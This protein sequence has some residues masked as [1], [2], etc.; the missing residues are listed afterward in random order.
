MNKNLKLNQNM[1]NDIKKNVNGSEKRYKKKF[2]LDKPKE[3]VEALMNAYLEEH[4]FVKSDKYK[5]Q[6]YRS[7]KAHMFGFNY[8]KWNYEEGQFALEAWVY[9]TLGMEWKMAGASF[10]GYTQIKPYRDSL[11][12]LVKSIKQ[13][14]ETNAAE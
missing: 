11:V 2:P 4:H 6:V 12:E 7:E 10:L 5:E 3:E 14:P 1:N 9:G 13:M 8:L